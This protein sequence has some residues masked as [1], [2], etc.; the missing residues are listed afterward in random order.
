MGT[1]LPGGVDSNCYGHSGFGSYGLNIG[2]GDMDD[3][4]DRRSSS[5]TTTTT[6]RPSTRTAPRSSQIPSYFTRRG[7]DCED[8]P[9]SWGQ[10]IRY[11]DPE[12]EEDH[13]HLHEGEWP[14]PSWTMWLQWTHSPPSVG[15]INGDGLNEVIGVPNAEQDEPY[16]TYHHAVMVLEGDYAA[17]GQS[18][19]APPAGV[20]GA[21][22][23]RR[24]PLQRRLVSAVA[25]SRRP[26]WPTSPATPGPRS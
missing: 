10:F 23:D 1:D 7:N 15:D 26:R 14:G 22:S 12:V 2:I 8:S 20:G 21:P 25:P 19:G 13:Y 3:D 6:S 17:N 4:D 16:H 24:A 18:L 11:L 9:M 5:P